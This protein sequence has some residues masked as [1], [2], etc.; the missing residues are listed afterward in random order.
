MLYY[1]QGKISYFIKNHRVDIQSVWKA[2]ETTPHHPYSSIHQS[3][4]SLQ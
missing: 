2:N 3:E 4:I 1:T